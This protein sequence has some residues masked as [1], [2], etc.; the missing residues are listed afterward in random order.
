MKNRP[1]NNQR[2]APIHLARSTPAP[3][4]GVVGNHPE[5][6]GRFEDPI[7]WR[8]EL[9][10]LVGRSSETIRLW[11]KNGTLPAPDSMPTTK[12]MGWKRSTLLARGFP[13]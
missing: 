12:L 1:H 10:K 2:I 9:R 11:M 7:V 4:Q 8:D 13:V 5:L 6:L 3:A